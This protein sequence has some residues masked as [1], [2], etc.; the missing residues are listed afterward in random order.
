M[1]WCG[2]LVECVCVCVTISFIRLWL[3]NHR[4]SRINVLLVWVFCRGKEYNKNDR[5]SPALSFKTNGNAPLDAFPPFRLQIILKVLI[6]YL[7][8]ATAH[9]LKTSSYKYT[10]GAETHSSY[11]V[12]A[13]VHQL[14]WDAQRPQ[15]DIQSPVSIE[16]KVVEVDGKPCFILG[17][18]T[19]T[20]QK[21]VSC[22]DKT[23]TLQVHKQISSDTSC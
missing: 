23:G 20:K 2:L 12:R 9:W 15:V 10:Q 8:V 1:Q 5:T 21:E 11:R 22:C 4:L 19:N 7:N 6:T 13:V 14:L 18:S 3:H 16:A 17:R